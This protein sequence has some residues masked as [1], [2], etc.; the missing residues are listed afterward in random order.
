MQN[1]FEQLYKDRIGIIRLPEGSTHISSQLFERVGWHRL[2][3]I[4]V[5]CAASRLNLYVINTPSLKYPDLA[6]CKS[7]AAWNEQH[8]INVLN[9]RTDHHSFLQ[10]FCFDSGHVFGFVKL[11]D[12]G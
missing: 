5:A 12:A 10:R 6:R 11:T 4:R 7:A 2:Q 1:D 9:I 3:Q 8:V